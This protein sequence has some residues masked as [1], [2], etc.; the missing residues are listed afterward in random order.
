MLRR[1]VAHLLIALVVFGALWGGTGRAAAAPNDRANCVGEFS[2]DFAGPGFGQFV[3]G[4]A[5][6]PGGEP[7]LGFFLGPAASSDTCGFTD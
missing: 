1:R 3:S 2:S 4:A 5:R 7:G 6:D